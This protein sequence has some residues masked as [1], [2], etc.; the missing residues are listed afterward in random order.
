[1]KFQ[2]ENIIEFQES[3]L[4]CRRSKCRRSKRRHFGNIGQNDDGQNVDGKEKKN[5][6][7]FNRKY[8]CHS[9]FITGCPDCA[10]KRKCILYPSVRIM[11]RLKTC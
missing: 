3:R 11:Y 6:L 4:K 2:N 1:M 7:F 9:Y 10:D 8:Y 5:N